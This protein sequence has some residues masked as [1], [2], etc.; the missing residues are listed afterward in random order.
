MFANDFN[1]GIDVL[2]KFTSGRRKVGRVS[3]GELRFKRNST[4]PTPTR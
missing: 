1:E 3:Y 4:G 2:I